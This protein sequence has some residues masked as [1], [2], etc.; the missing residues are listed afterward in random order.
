MVGIRSRDKGVRGEAESE[1]G[2]LSKTGR[3]YRDSTNGNRY[4]GQ[5]FR[6]R[7]SQPSLVQIARGR[8]PA[9]LWLRSRR[10]AGELAADVGCSLL[11]HQAKSM[12]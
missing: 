1:G 9:R 8:K 6:V 2:S 12:Q 7:K 11:I 4:S 5:P 3:Q 10:L